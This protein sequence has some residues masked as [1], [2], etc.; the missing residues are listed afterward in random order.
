VDVSGGRQQSYIEDCQVCCK[1]NILHISWD[2]STGEYTISAD[3][4]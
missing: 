3:L 4:E 2:A 1:P